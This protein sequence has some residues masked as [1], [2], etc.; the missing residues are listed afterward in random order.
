[1]TADAAWEE[2]NEA[3]QHCTPLCAD[4][5]LFTADGLTDEERT[6]CASV[7]TRCPLLDPCR[8]YAEAANVPSGFWAGYAYTP[9]GRK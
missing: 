7:C 8:T 1:M 9:K 2:L 6:L 5:A 4:L 3:L